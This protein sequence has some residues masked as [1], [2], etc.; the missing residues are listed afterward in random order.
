MSFPVDVLLLFLFLFL[1]SLLQVPLYGG[2][3]VSSTSFGGIRITSNLAVDG[4]TMI[5]PCQNGGIEWSQ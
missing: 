3:I 4:I 1:L 5:C 2:L